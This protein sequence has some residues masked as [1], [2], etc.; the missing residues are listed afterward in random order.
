M[1]YV[2]LLLTL[3]AVISGSA[4]IGTAMQV[5]ARHRKIVVLYF[6][7][8]ILSLVLML[9]GISITDLGLIDPRLNRD[10]LRFVS[11][12]FMA[13]GGL[14]HVL[15]LPRLF[16]ALIGEPVGPVRKISYLSVAIVFFVIALFVLFRPTLLG[17]QLVLN[18]MLFGMIAYVIIMMGIRMS[19]IGDK[20]LR[21]AVRLFFVLS[22]AFFPLMY[23]DSV[24]PF[25]SAPA[26]VASVDGTSLPLYFLVLNTLSIWLA[27]GYLNEAPYLAS[28][29][30]TDHFGGSF[31]LSPREIEIVQAAM[32]G[33]SNKEIGEKLFISPKTVENHLYNIYQKTDVRNRVQLVNLIQGNKAG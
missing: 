15:A 32:N 14:L 11:F 29:L 10:T 8:F 28:G 21:R 3:S 33:D 9:G 25:V 16:H 2:R 30:I 26:W 20:R 12:V 24:L 5:F 27:S 22:A 17:P 19:R 6:A 7:G 4:G 18:S 23:V 1:I 13:I 31:G